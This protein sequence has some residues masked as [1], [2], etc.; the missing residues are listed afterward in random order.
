ME[1][2]LQRRVIAYRTT[3]AIVKG[4]LRDGIITEE[5]YGDIDTI[6]ANK[7][8]LSSCSIYR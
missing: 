1:Q 4:M 6:I 5:E 2:D 3:M 7:Y 8:G